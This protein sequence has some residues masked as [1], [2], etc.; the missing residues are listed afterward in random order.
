MWEYKV[1]YTLD[2]VDLVLQ[3]RAGEGCLKPIRW[4]RNVDELSSRRYLRR[5]IEVILIL[6]LVVMMMVMM[7]VMIMMMLIGEKDDDDENEKTGKKN[8]KEC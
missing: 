1:V 5:K 8:Y 4:V 3:R 6:L 7:M 2:N